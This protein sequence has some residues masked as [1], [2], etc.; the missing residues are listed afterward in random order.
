MTRRIHFDELAPFCMLKGRV[1]CLL[2]GLLVP[3]ERGPTI[4]VLSV[5]RLAIF[6]PDSSNFEFWGQ[7]PGHSN[8]DLRRNQK[9]ADPR[10]QPTHYMA[11]HVKNHI[12]KYSFMTISLAA[13]DGIQAEEM[14]CR[15]TPKCP[16]QAPGTEESRGS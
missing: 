10:H 16:G 3:A 7:H 5:S 6:F 12:H 9:G 14:I 4:C 8:C 13:C 11:E 1:H 2:V 15:G